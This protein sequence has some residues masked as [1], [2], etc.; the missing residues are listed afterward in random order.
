MRIGIELNGVLRNTIGKFTQIYEKLVLEQSELD[1]VHKFES[2]I[3]DD[4]FQEV[5][6]DT[7]KEFKYEIKSDVT[8]LN[9]LDHFSF[10]SNEELYEFMYEE[11]AMSIFGHASSAE[12]STFHDLQDIYLKYRDKHE[13]L[14]VSD[15]MGKSKPASLFFISKFGCQIEK[16]K[17]YSQLTL[18]S[19]WNEIDILL[20][21]NPDLLLNYPKNKILVKYETNYNK[22]VSS[23]FTISS[24][25]EFDNVLEGILKQN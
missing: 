20:T 23:E 4:D 18:N 10:E 13:L 17:F 24:I 25:K 12:Y 1:T 7:S 16:I 15:E 11:H 6:D 9:L 5:F 19:M 3:G 2:T 22:H 14:I 8:S 21:A